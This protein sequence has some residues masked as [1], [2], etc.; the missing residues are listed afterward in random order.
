MRREKSLKNGVHHANGVVWGPVYRTRLIHAVHHAQ[1]LVRAVRA[2]AL[3]FRVARVRADRGVRL[4]LR[5]RRG[6]GRRHRRRRRRGRR[7]R[8]RRRGVGN[9][10][11][12]RLDRRD[13][14]R[15]RLRGRAHDVQLER[16]G[17]LVHDG[18]RGVLDDDRGHGRG[19]LR[20]LP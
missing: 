19:A 5:L 3:A 1:D 6:R 7:R 2:H 17:Y 11:R 13:R 15:G 10:F 8:R 18:R 16:G 12:R 4:R 14:V 9:A 20:R